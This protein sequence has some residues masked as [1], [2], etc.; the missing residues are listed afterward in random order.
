MKC[1]NVELG[2]MPVDSSLTVDVDYVKSPYT[3]EKSVQPGE[4]YSV[5]N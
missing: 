3:V 1:A 4:K 2:I 5:W